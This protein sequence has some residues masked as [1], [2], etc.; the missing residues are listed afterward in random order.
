MTKSSPKL[1]DIPII[2]PPTAK[3]TPGAKLLQQ[4]TSIDVVAPAVVGI[5]ALVIWELFVR[6]TN[7]PPFLL[8]GPVL[9]I[10]TLVKDWGLL[11]PSLITTI[12]ITLVAFIAAVISGVAISVLFVQSKWIERSFFPYAVVLQTTPIV[13]IAPL[14]ILWIRR[15]VPEP[16]TTFAALVV[17][18][19]IV[20]FFPIISNTTLGLNSV[21][22]SLRNVFQLYRASKWQTLIYLQLPAALPYFLGGLKI[23]GGLA[24]IGAVVAEFVAGTG[25][26][27]AGLAYQILMASYNLQIPRMFAALLMT[28]ILGVVIFVSLTAL[29]DFLLKN[30]HESAI[31]RE[32]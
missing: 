23:S 24:L 9:V 5:V 11:F 14:I 32:N 27:K 30:W 1:S 19:W 4:L 10:Q 22:H 31:K 15:V 28:T 20:A 8:P 12:Q 3:P 6:V 17:C 25:G 7:L 29:S 13:A 18:A 16:N 2:A 26:A 21:D